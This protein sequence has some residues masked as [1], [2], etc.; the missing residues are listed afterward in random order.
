MGAGGWP[1]RTGSPGAGAEGQWA[2]NDD[3]LQARAEAGRH[4]GAPETRARRRLW[5]GKWAVSVYGGG[6][7]KMEACDRVGVKSPR[8]IGSTI[9]RWKLR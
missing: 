8:F 3:G 4:A 6:A 7:A 9:D 5:A 2:G 1:S